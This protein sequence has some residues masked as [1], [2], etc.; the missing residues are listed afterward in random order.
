MFGE[1]DYHPSVWWHTSSAYKTKQRNISQNKYC[2]R[3]KKEEEITRLPYLNLKFMNSLQNRLNVS[4]FLFQNH[5]FVVETKKNLIK[6]SPGNAV[7]YLAGINPKQSL[8]SNFMLC[9][10]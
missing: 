8:V 9:L 10:V 7:T 4:G 5:Q 3:R 6:V 2:R 1:D